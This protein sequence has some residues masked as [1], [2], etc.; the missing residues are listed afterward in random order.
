MKPVCFVVFLI[1]ALI[2]Q[3]NAQSKRSFIDRPVYPVSVQLKGTQLAIQAAG[4]STLTNCKPYLAWR[5]AGQTDWQQTTG[6]VLKIVR[7]SADNL[8]FQTRFAQVNAT[9]TARRIDASTWEFSGQLTNLGKAAVELARFHYLHGTVGLRAN[10]FL[11]MDGNLISPTDTL[12]AP[13]QAHE[14][15]WRSFGVSWPRLSEPIHDAPNWATSVDVGILTPAYNR[16]GWF[17]GFVGPGTAF[18]EVGFQTGRRAGQTAPSVFYAGVLLDNVRLEPGTTRP[19]ETCR[20]SYGDWQEN[21][22]SW[23][24]TCASEF[25]V[26]KP[27][28]PLVGYCSWYQNA[29]GIKSADIDRAIREVAEWPIPPGGR[30]VQID[31]GYEQMPGDWQSNDKFADG[32]AT[33]PA[34][35][36]QTGSLPGLWIAPTT[37][38]GTHP[39]IRE[40]PDW[41]QR[42][43]NGEKAISFMNWAQYNHASTEA[44][45]KT[46]YLE[47]DRPE[48]RTFVSQIFANL[49]QQGWR[50]L[51]IDFT[52]P[53]STARVAF[54]RHKTSFETQRELYA[55][56]RKASGPAMLL[57]ACIG[58]LGRYALGSVD[59]ARI[60][61][62]IGTNWPTV[63]GNLRQLFMGV[64][65]NGIWW[66]ADPDVF[67]LRREKNA[68]DDEENY[69]LTGSVG[70]MGGVLLTSDFP[71]QWSALAKEKLKP[72]WNEN[73]PRVPG[74][75]RILYTPGGEPM[76]YVV[77]YADGKKPQHRVGLYNWQD[78][79]ATVRVSLPALGFNPDLRWNITGL[80][81]TTA[82]LT[83]KQLTVGPQPA[84]SLRIIELTAPD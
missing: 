42:L 14:Q 27:R 31:D 8:Q 80:D 7:K 51:K 24:S 21:L 60:G 55:R 15:L 2:G 65:T 73:G 30:T 36:A 63:R 37:I 29:A 43:P 23:A 68:L 32:W 61:G 79:P 84:H 67:Y 74:R 19:L 1:L 49:K 56:I 47:P 6:S 5:L 54:D 62:D 38:H 3:M 48:A 57:N 28:S 25:H 34:R 70:L 20:I 71:S 4:G 58:D 76:A 72:F 77:S 64:P 69:L 75:H 26:P 83:N 13:R 53:V 35:I 16:P 45:K 59:I 17:I 46:Y 66:Q 81:N 41:L 82:A 11:R 12:P 9:I 22:K 33:L 39:F 18:G 78:T 50:Y 52:Y 44:E 10:Q 40:H